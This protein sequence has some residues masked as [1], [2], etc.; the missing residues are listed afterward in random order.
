MTRRIPGHRGARRAAASMRYSNPFFRTSLPAAKTIGASRHPA[1]RPVPAAGGRLP[2]QVLNA[3]PVMP[4]LCRV[5]WRVS[6]AGANR[7]VS[8]PYGS[9]PLRSRVAPSATARSL[10]SALHAVIQAAR[11]NAARAARR[12]SSCR[13]ATYT[14]DPWRLIT[15]GSR[16]PAAMLAMNPPGTTQCPCTTVAP[17]VR[18]TRAAV[19]MPAVMARGVT[20]R[21]DARK[22]TSALSAPA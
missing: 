1:S 4:S 7:V 17:A 20:A 10:R 11:E 13:S 16:L 6:P 5:A 12:A 19:R 2:A 15:S 22:L 3:S 8:T 14:S 9:T 18:A 21:A